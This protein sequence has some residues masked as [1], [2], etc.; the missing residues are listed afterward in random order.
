MENRVEL[1]GFSED[2]DKFV[3]SMVHARPTVDVFA[4]DEAA[5]VDVLHDLITESLNH[6]YFLNNNI[7]AQKLN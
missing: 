7:F 2:R 5:T 3:A 4:V 1:D 6:R